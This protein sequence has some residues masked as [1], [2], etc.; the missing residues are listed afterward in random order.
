MNLFK[1]ITSATSQNTDY[2]PAHMLAEVCAR[3]K[4]RIAALQSEQPLVSIVVPAHNEERY[5]LRMVE[6]M[7][8]IQTQFPLE[9]I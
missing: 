2:I 9:I 6:S 5:M 4:E 8:K 3:Y 1:S 7:S